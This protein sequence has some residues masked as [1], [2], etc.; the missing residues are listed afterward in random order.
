MHSGCNGK[1]HGGR[2]TAP[3][4]VPVARRCPPARRR[5]AVTLWPP[6][7]RA[8][9]RRRRRFRTRPRCAA[10]SCARNVCR[11][12]GGTRTAS[13][14]PCPVPAVLPL[15]ATEHGW[16]LCIDPTGPCLRVVFQGQL[17]GSQG[18]RGTARALAASCCQPRP[19][20]ATIAPGAADVAGADN[21]R[22]FG[23]TGAVRRPWGTAC[24]ARARARTH[25]QA[26]QPRLP[27]RT[28]TR[29]SARSCNSPGNDGGLGVL[30]NVHVHLA[31]ARSQPRQEPH[32]QAGFADDSGV[33]PPFFFPRRPVQ[34][35]C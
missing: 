31:A 30:L 15:C 12:Q 9:D 14:C 8:G 21:Q 23:G 19:P 28:G 25:S 35:T 20:A 26:G 1:G 5:R 33:T 10:S 2:L 22:P 27:T 11:T 7:Q 13:P 6:R 3:V 24:G 18:T 4:G 29:K 17:D 32:R 34:Q 16:H